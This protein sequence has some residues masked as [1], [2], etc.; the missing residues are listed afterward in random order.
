MFV[1][2]CLQEIVDSFLAALLS[3]PLKELVVPKESRQLLYVG[4]AS[5]LWSFL[6]RFYDF[7]QNLE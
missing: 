2:H 4:R 6:E 7:L 3:F 1:G 5:L